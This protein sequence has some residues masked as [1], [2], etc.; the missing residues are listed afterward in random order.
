MDNKTK[1]WKIGWFFRIWHIHTLFKLRSSQC[2]IKKIEWYNLGMVALQEIKWNNKSTLDF[3]DTTIFYR[4]C[5][6]QCQFGTGFAVHKSIVSLVIEFKSINPR[7]LI[8]KIK[9]QVFDIK[10]VNGHVSTKEKAPEK[11]NEFSD[12]L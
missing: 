5:N 11:K 9:R 6:D 12:N 2:L 1:I 10:F 7:I 4:E 8:L 3:Q